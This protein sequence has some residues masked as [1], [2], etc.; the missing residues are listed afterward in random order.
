MRAIVLQSCLALCHCVDYSPLGSSVQRILQARILEWV[1][2]AILQGIFPTQGSNT[3]LFMSS[4]LAGQFTVHKMN[5][6][7]ID[8]HKQV[9][10]PGCVCVCMLWCSVIS[11]SLQPHGLWHA[12]LLCP[13]IF[14]RQE[15]WVGCHFLFQRMFPTQGSNTHFLFLLHWKV[16]SLPQ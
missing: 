8:P 12:R 14:S 5:P 6:I 11:G 9:F 16:I 1:T 10:L 4:A 13:W 3:C 15:C 2:S 7:D